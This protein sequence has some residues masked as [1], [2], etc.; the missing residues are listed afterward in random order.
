MKE[1]PKGK[2]RNLT[3]FWS[4][5]DTQMNR[6]FLYRNKNG[7]WVGKGGEEATF[8]SVGRGF[9]D[10]EKDETI[11]LEKENLKRSSDKS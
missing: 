11:R 6:V 7:M 9:R 5:G 4:K 1:R 8:S 2:S 10:D 3:E